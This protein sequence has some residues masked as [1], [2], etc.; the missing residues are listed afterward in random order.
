MNSMDAFRRVFYSNC[1]LVNIPIAIAQILVVPCIY[2][3][4]II[5]DKVSLSLKTSSFCVKISR[6]L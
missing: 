5:A 2:G 3:V 4:F 1:M 6:F